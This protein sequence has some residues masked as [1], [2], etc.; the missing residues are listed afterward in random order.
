M[1]EEAKQAETFIGSPDAYIP[2][3]E[4]DVRMF[5]HDT[6]HL[7]HDKDYRT[8]AAFPPP[9]LRETAIH[10]VRV[11]PWGRARLEVIAGVKCNPKLSGRD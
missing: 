7:S 9:T 1:W 4:S 5:C 6:F 2:I 11:D 10:V 3:T 8:P